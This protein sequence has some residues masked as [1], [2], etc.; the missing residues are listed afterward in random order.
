MSGLFAAE[1]AANRPAKGIDG[2][3]SIPQLYP[4][5][6]LPAA[7]C[8]YLTCRRWERLPA[9]GNF[10]NAG[11]RLFGGVLSGHQL[12]NFRT[13]SEKVRRNADAIYSEY[14]C[15]ANMGGQPFAANRTKHFCSFL[16]SFP[17]HQRE[18]ATPPSA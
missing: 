12:E 11:L 15:L 17:R 16:V 5:F 13:F 1:P 8:W 3:A 2:M 4:E 9:S 18:R 14:F 10:I 6:A 7:G